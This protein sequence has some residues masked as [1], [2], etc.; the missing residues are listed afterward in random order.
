[1]RFGRVRACRIFRE[2]FL[3]ALPN[4]YVG[5]RVSGNPYW[6]DSKKDWD[7]FACY[8]AEINNVIGGTKLL[9]LCTY[10]LDKCGVLE[11]M[12]VVRNHEF[13]LAMSHGEWQLVS[14]P[15]SGHRCA[16]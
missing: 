7:D 8:E 4:G 3:D 6:I 2:N 16:Q 15:G 14:M 10:S 11:V 12:D 13:A 5:M 1:M 9:V